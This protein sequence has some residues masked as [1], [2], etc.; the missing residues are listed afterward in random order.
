MENF[1][2]RHCGSKTYSTCMIRGDVLLQ[3][4][5]SKSNNDTFQYGFFV[6]DGCST[7]F[8]DKEK[9]SLSEKQQKERSRIMTKLDDVVS[10]SMEGNYD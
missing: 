1:C 5:D 7:I 6:C 4:Y 9:F 10:R 8:L 3:L 2:C